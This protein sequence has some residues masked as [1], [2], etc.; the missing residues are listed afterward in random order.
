[1]PPI[2]RRFIP[3]SVRLRS[4]L[5]LKNGRWRLATPDRVMLE[6][7]I[8]PEFL[9]RRDIRRMLDVGVAWYT[10]TYPRLYKGIEYHSIDVDPAMQRIAGSRHH[11]L[12]MTDLATV[13]PADTFDL[14]VCNGVF[15]WG[16][17]TAEQVARGLD[18]CADVLRPG[19]WLVVG[20]NDMEGRRIPDLDALAGRRFDRA[21][22]P[23]ARADHLVTPTHYAHRY[24]FFTRR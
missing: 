18:A 10:R 9:G 14:V 4:R 3:R 6:D 13:Y 2:W 15:G 19:G 5:R 7:V 11:T 22:L 21:V 20:W 16:L 23:A 8:A 24:D 12:S 17:N 1:M